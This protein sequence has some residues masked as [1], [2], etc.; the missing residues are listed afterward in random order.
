MSKARSIDANCI[1]QCDLPK[2]HKS[3]LTLGE[4]RNGAIVFFEGA[5]AYEV[6]FKIGGEVYMKPAPP[7][8]EE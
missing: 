3:D 2:Y 5:G 1:E 4:L 8:K 6:V 7:K